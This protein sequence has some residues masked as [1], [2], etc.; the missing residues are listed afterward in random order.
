MKNTVRAYLIEPQAVFSPYLERLLARA[1]FEVVGVRRDVD[2]RELASVAPAAVVVDVDF[3]ERGGPT[4]LCRIREA[5]RSA[6]LI[7]LSDRLDPA[8]TTTCMI[9]GASAVVG[10]GLDAATRLR[11]LRLALEIAVT[12]ERT[13]SPSVE[14]AGLEPAA[15]NLQSWRSTN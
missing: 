11:E 2:P 10:K 3:V 7:A 9:S 4:A 13:A 5:A 14:M 15:S 8:F 12:A 1:G 6:A